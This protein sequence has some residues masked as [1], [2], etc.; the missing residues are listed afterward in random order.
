MGNVTQAWTVLQKPIWIT[1]YQ[2]YGTDAEQ[3]AFLQTVIPWL[4]AQS[5]VA[6]Y[7]YF[8]IFPN[9]LLDA[10]GTGLSL[11]GQAYINS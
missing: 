2:C 7:A 4:D 8:G 11:A 3:A 1:E 9:Y 6:R 5:Y 10:A